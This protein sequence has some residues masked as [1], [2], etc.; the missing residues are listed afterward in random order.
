MCN[1]DSFQY[2]NS[3]YSLDY[4]PIEDDVSLDHNSLATETFKPHGK[5]QL[6]NTIFFC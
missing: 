1:Q 4:R 6:Y 5:F 3:V 2:R